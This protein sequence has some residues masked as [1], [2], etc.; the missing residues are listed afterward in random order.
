MKFYD[1]VLFCMDIT[2]QHSIAGNLDSLEKN[3]NNAVFLYKI[4]SNAVLLFQIHFVISR[5]E[6]KKR[7]EVEIVARTEAEVKSQN[8]VVAVTTVM[9]IRRMWTLSYVDIEVSNADI[10]EVYVKQAMFVLW[11]KSVSSRTVWMTVI[12]LIHLLMLSQTTT[13]IPKWWL[14]SWYSY[15]GTCSVGRGRSVPFL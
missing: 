9:T 14:R 3:E 7:V 13:I 2:S 10:P 4:G 11:D 8:V 15:R 1:F 12:H 6:V 5:V